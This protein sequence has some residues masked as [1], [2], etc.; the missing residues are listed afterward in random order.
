MEKTDISKEELKQLLAF[1]HRIKAFEKTFIIQKDSMNRLIWGLLLLGAGILDCMLIELQIIT[2][3]VGILT[4]VPWLIAIFSGLVLQ[5]FSN[6]HLTNVYSIQREKESDSSGNMYLISG[7]LL[8][9]VLITFYNA[10]RLHY[11]IFPSISLISGFMSLI[12]DREQYRENKDLIPKSSYLINPIVSLFAALI[13]IIS[14]LIDNSFFKF[15]GLIFGL[16]FGG[17]FILSAFWNRNQIDNYI[18]RID[19]E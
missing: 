13:M 18:K 5:L 19:L 6:R 3:E 16:S 8:M 14:Y 12:L 2:D 9:G 4:T 10:N 1:M 11:L 7:F 17:S 15:H